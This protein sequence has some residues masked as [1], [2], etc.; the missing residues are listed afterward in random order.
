VNTLLLVIP[1]VKQCIIIIGSPENDEHI[2]LK[3]MVF[4][5]SL[6]MLAAMWFSYFNV[7]GAGGFFFTIA[8]VIMI[9]TYKDEK[10]KI[11]K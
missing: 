6:F 5:F 3:T 9:W 1:L 11:K 7:K 10:F 8:I 4:M 2:W